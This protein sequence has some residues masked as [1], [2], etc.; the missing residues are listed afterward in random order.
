[1][2]IIATPTVTELLSRPVT[3][4]NEIQLRVARLLSRSLIEDISNDLISAL[5]VLSDRPGPASPD[6]K[7]DVLFARFGFPV[8]R[9]PAPKTEPLTAEEAARITDQFRRATRQLVQV[10]PYRVVTQ[11]TENL[12]R[13]RALHDHLPG[14]E[15]ALSYL[16]RYALAILDVLDLM[17]DDE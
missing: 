5:D 2:G 8:A 4:E 16:R 17:G 7:R 15:D 6:R 14:P 11:P 10:L 3:S 13:L 1:M 12:R 9:R